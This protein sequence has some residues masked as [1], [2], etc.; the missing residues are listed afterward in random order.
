[1]TDE[2]RAPM[3]DWNNEPRAP[4]TWRRARF[5]TFVEHPQETRHVIDRTF[6]GDV[7]YVSGRFSRFAHRDQCTF[8][9][10]RSWATDGFG[11]K[12]VES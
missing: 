5:Y 11:A 12:K 10:W 9:Q 8:A 6:G 1:M 3:G 2:Q 4:S 7:I